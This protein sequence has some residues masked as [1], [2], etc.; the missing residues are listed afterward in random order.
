MVKKS[1][2]LLIVTA[3]LGSSLWAD[4]PLP[5]PVPYEAAEF[6]DWMHDLRRGEI[7]TIGAVPYAYL[8]SNIAYPWFVFFSHCFNQDFNPLTMNGDLYPG[9]DLKYGTGAQEFEN[10]VKKERILI[11]TV[12]VSIGIAIADY[13]IRK[14]DKKNR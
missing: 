6:S 9:L 11:T 13:I 7:V 3:F 10:K 2:A 1:I 14:S 12:V 8:I 5:T 4:G